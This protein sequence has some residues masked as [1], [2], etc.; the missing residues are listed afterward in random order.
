MTLFPGYQL[1]E[2]FG[3]N[4]DY[5]TALDHTGVEE[6][7]SYITLD[8]AGIDPALL[9]SSSSYRLIVH[10]ICST[11]RHAVLITIFRVWTLRP[12]ICN[13]QVPF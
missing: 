2:T 11:P 5:E 13:Y 6:V 1:V 4:D 7:V 3:S 12:H 10:L 8:I 9:A